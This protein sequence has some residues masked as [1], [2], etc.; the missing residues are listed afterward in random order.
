L[1]VADGLLTQGLGP[2]G[3]VEVAGVLYCL[4]ATEESSLLDL[5]SHMDAEV[6]SN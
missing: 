5:K 2:D 4:G 6:A 1:N 3:D